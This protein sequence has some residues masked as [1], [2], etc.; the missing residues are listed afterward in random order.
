M[1]TSMEEGLYFCL[2]NLHTWQSVTWQ[3]TILLL[4]KVHG[5]NYRNSYN[6]LIKQDLF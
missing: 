2:Q 1:R 6:H 5:S 4:A 3:R